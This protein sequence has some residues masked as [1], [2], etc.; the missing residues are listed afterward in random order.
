[1]RL[2]PFLV[3]PSFKARLRTLVVFTPLGFPPQDFDE[4]P[5][6]GLE[7]RAHIQRPPNERSVTPMFFL[8]RALPPFYLP[9]FSRDRTFASFFPPPS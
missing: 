2:I 8:F 4:L 6:P 3:P 5:P 9:T 1:M 7:R